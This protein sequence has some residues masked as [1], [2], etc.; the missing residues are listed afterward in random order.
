MSDNHGG[1]GNS[2]FLLP[3]MLQSISTQSCMNV[4]GGNGD[5][6]FHMKRLALYVWQLPQNLLGWGIKTVLCIKNEGNGIYHWKA[7]SGLSLGDYIFVNAHASDLMVRHEA[8][9]RRQSVMLGPLYLL[10]VGL[11]SFL[12]ASLKR[13]GLFKDRDYYSFYTERWADKLAGIER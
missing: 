7:W 1:S 13:A 9:H 6:I 3:P 12:W 4:Q 10:V 11:P 5:L 2:P 8:G